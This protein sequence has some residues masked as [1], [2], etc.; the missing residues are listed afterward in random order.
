MYRDKPLRAPALGDWA[1]AGDLE[2][3]GRV[4][5]SDTGPLDT[6]MI[7]QA[8]AGYYACITHLDHQIGRLLMEFGD[9][10]L[11][12]NTVILFTSDHGELL[13]DH[14]LYRKGRPYQ[15]SIHIPM[16]LSGPQKLIGARNKTSGALAELRDVMPTLLDFA[17]YGTQSAL[18]GVSLRRAA[19]EPDFTPR[20][21]LHGEHFW[22]E[23]SHHFIVTKTD[24]YIWHSQTGI[25]QYFDLAADPREEKNLIKS[26]AKADRI[27]YLKAKLILELKWREEGFTDG[28]QLFV[29]RP[30]K[31]YLSTVNHGK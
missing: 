28:A 10:G 19:T 14:R 15:G 27:A 24:K 16:I 13:C 25:E 31:T 18:E 2:K 6:E 11:A 1:D 22:G 20:E 23:R 8:Q 9:Q 7:R 30:L 21:Y 5:D 3:W 12:D 17:G 26:K 29:G 4:F